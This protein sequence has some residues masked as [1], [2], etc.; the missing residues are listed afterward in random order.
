MFQGDEG[1][2]QEENFLKGEISDIKQKIENIKSKKDTSDSE[3]LRLRIKEVNSYTKFENIGGDMSDYDNQEIHTAKKETLRIVG[4]LWTETGKAVEE[5]GPNIEMLAALER[6]QIILLKAVQCL[7][8]EY[9]KKFDPIE[10]MSI[11][12][13]IS[14]LEDEAK[15]KEDIIRKRQDA[16]QVFSPDDPNYYTEDEQDKEDAEESNKKSKITKF[17]KPKKTINE[18]DYDDDDDR[19]L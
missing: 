16:D 19:E 15:E 1:D 2:R 5:C 6:R 4:R 11:E 10:E 13:R 7:G 8:K 3:L 9:E 14:L 17:R 12:D 18:S